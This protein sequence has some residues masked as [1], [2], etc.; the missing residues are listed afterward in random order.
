MLRVRKALTAVPRE[1]LELPQM[2]GE[3]I[4]AD[5][6]HMLARITAERLEVERRLAR[7]EDALNRLTLN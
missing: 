7:A 3:Q 6:S 5:W 4:S 1:R 2:D